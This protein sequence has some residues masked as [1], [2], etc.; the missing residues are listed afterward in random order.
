MWTKCLLAPAC[1]ALRGDTTYIEG[2]MRT[3]SAKWT[4][5][6]LKVVSTDVALAV[7]RLL[8]WQQIVGDPSSTW[9]FLFCLFLAASLVCLMLWTMMERPHLSHIRGC[10]CWCP[11]CRDSTTCSS[12]TIWTM[13]WLVR[14]NSSLILWSRKRFST[15]MSM[16]WSPSGRLHA[17]RLSERATRGIVE[18]EVELPF[19]L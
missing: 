19:C 13:Q 7:Q 8:W 2:H 6:Q 12:S 9:S 15:Q 14:R 18:G 16:C 17:S 10:V 4:W 5:K 3:T 11:I 1:K